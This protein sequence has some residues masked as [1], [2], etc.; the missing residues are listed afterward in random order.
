MLGRKT[1]SGRKLKWR[2]V[3][4]GTPKRCIYIYILYYIYYIYI[5]SIGYSIPMYILVIYIICYTYYHT[6]AY[7]VHII[8][9]YIRLFTQLIE[10]THII[11]IIHIGL[12]RIVCAR[13]CVCAIC[14]GDVFDYLPT[15]NGQF[16]QQPGR[17]LLPSGI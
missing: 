7:Y 4:I 2:V 8:Y 15:R 6:Y 17:G 3:D 13:V 5:I 14:D 9:I 1:K 12:A 10:H 11:Y 16:N